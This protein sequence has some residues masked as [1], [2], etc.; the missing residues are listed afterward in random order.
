MAALFRRAALVVLASFLT[1]S[2]LG[3]SASAVSDAASSNNHS[4]KSYGGCG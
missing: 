2:A 4:L 1:F 3:A